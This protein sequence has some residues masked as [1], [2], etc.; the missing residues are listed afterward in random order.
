L[1]V[2]V[3][4]PKQANVCYGDQAGILLYL[5]DSEWVKLVVEGDK[6][7]P[8]AGRMIVFAHMASAQHV[9]VVKK[10]ENV[11]SKACRLQLELRR[12]AGCC[13]AIASFNG[14]DEFEFDV[15]RDFEAA[16]F[17]VMA[18]LNL[19]RAPLA[20][21]HWFHFSDFS[22]IRNR[23]KPK[24]TNANGAAAAKLSSTSA[25]VVATPDVDKELPA[26]IENKTQKG[27]KKA[28][29]STGDDMRGNLYKPRCLRIRGDCH[30]N[31]SWPGVRAAA[32]HSAT[33][34]KCVTRMS[35]VH[36]THNKLSR[37]L[38]SSRG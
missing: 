21:E 28:K 17:G 15:S 11:G 12:G 19:P 37:E 24:R 27:T 22:G 4:L 9:P 7:E 3:A 14:N 10:W 5:S 26:P 23:T 6:Q 35:V 16:F 36:K 25:A 30:R 31:T 32:I 29:P 34:A 20:H 33:V 8:T 18:H 38:Q 1:K 2:T 13:V